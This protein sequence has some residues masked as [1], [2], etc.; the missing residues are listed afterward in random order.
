MIDTALFITRPDSFDIRIAL[1]PG[2][3]LPVVLYRDGRADKPGI[4]PLF[5]PKPE[6]VVAPDTAMDRKMD[7]MKA[8]PT[9]DQEAEWPGT[10]EGDN[11]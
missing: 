9:M 2:N 6:L 8:P 3:S 7:Y 10:W 5:R 11:G 1:L 4:E